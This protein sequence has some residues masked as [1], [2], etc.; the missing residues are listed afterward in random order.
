MMLSS[1]C[2]FMEITN[3]WMKMCG[4]QV[5]VAAF[6]EA[7]TDRNC[8]LRWT[9]F[10]KTT[11]FSDHDLTI[12][13]EWFQKLQVDGAVDFRNFCLGWVHYRHNESSG[14]F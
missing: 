7:D 12:C 3:V 11:P 6:A 5:I 2:M 10:C 14:K 8:V 9:E 1:L 13:G 4:F